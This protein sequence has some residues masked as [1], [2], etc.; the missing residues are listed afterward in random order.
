MSVQTENT[1]SAETL[2]RQVRL[3]AQLRA[4][5]A[6]ATERAD[7]LKEAFARDNHDVL[8][9]VQM[10]AQDLN[11]A[12]AKLREMALEAFLATGAKRPVSGVAIQQ[13]SRLL[14][15]ADAALAWAIEQQRP[16]L[17]QLRRADF[18]RVA[19]ALASAGVDDALPF[20]ESETLPVATI[21]TD[22][23][24][25]AKEPPVEAGEMPELPF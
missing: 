10:Y 7:A 22:L 24:P 13:R 3:V 2:Q 21:A 23:S 16:A 6:V 14:Y 11:E 4:G 8:W 18:E 19:K 15:D 25:L 9:Q 20:V 17:L 1:I 5:K 12:E